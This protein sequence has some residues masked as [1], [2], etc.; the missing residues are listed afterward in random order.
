EILG[1]GSGDEEGGGGVWM[2]GNEH[3]LADDAGVLWLGPANQHGTVVGELAGLDGDTV[4]QCIDLVGKDSDGVVIELRLGEVHGASCGSW[5]VLVIVELIWVCN[6]RGFG[7]FSETFFTRTSPATTARGTV[8]AQPNTP[9]TSSLQC[10][11]FST[12]PGHRPR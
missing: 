9:A 2:V 5:F 7:D 6:A 8:E 10:F 1:D 12:R 3:V 11:D 4:R